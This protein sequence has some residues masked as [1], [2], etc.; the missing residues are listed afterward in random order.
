MAD[1][2]GIGDKFVVIKTEDVGK[3]LNYSGRIALNHV[4][5]VIEDGR[6]MDG[7][8][9]NNY[10]VINTDEQYA[11]QVIDLMKTHNHWG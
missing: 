2:A 9:F 3:Y 1:V 5:E 8:K 7:K 4:L 10:V 11:D 6:S